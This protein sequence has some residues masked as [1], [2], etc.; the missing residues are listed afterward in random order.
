MGLGDAKIA[1][2]MGLLLGFSLGIPALIISFWSGAIIGIFLMALCRMGALFLPAQYH[3][4]K[5]KILPFGPFLAFGTVFAFIFE[6]SIFDIA[7]FL[8]F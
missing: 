5:G 1:L 2:G 7:S 3:T 4:L 6:P 8:T